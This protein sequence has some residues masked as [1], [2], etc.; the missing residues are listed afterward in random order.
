MGILASGTPSH[1]GAITLGFNT[2]SSSATSSH[3]GPCLRSSVS[4]DYGP[5]A[6]SHIRN[7]T[8][9]IGGSSGIEGEVSTLLLLL[10]AWLQASIANDSLNKT[11]PPSAT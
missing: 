6:H 10:R 4:Q 2:L 8:S 1:S 11:G 7:S 3:S 5:G 9:F